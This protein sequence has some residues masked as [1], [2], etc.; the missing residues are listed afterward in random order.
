MYKWVLIYS[1]KMQH[2]C[3]CSFFVCSYF[4]NSVWEMSLLLIINSVATFLHL[5]KLLFIVDIPSEQWYTMKEISPFFQILHGNKKSVLGR[6]ALLCSISTLKS[7]F[8]Q[9]CLDFGLYTFFFFTAS[10]P[11]CK[12]RSEKKSIASFSM[13]TIVLRFVIHTL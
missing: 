13:L 5:L 6:I 7:I 12:H 11:W 4:N 2:A 1:S 9:R 3:M 8:S 10:G